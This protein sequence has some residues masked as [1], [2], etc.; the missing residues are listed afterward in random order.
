MPALSLPPI[1]SLLSW[2]H[3]K[4]FVL[5]SITHTFFVIEIKQS[6]NVDKKLHINLSQDGGV[7]RQRST[8]LGVASTLP[9][10]PNR[11]SFPT[12]GNAAGVNLQTPRRHGAWVCPQAERRPAGVRD[13][14]EAKRLSLP[15][16]P[17]IL[18]EGSFGPKSPSLHSALLWGWQ[19]PPNSRSE[20]CIF[21]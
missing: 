4:A 20:L 17:F 7:T 8:F 6:G 18:L 9:L 10:S 11:V 5:R 19:T 1:F 14:L 2:N 15:P 13:D 16:V 12:S 3:T 21:G